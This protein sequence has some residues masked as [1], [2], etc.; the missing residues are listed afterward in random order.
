MKLF[1]SSCRCQLYLPRVWR[2]VE[3]KYAV[4]QAWIDLPVGVRG[5]ELRVQRLVRGY[6]HHFHRQVKGIVSYPELEG[7]ILGSACYMEALFTIYLRHAQE[8]QVIGL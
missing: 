6:D 3:L 5:L 7:L 2:G 1:F 8:H 4:G